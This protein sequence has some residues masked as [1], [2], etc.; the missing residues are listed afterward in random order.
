[1]NNAGLNALGELFGREAGE[2]YKDCGIGRK[3]RRRFLFAG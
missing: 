3:C 1:M 2:F